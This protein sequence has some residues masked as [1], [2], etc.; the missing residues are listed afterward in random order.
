MKILI[1]DDHPIVVEALSQIIKAQFPNAKVYAVETGKAIVQKL[2]TQKI[3]FLILDIKLLDGNSLAVLEDI[4]TLDLKV[5][6]VVFSTTHVADSFVKFNKGQV[7][8][9]VHKNIQNSDLRKIVSNFLLQKEV[10]KIDSEYF[11][12]ANTLGKH[13]NT[14]KNLFETLSKNELLVM[15]LL[16]NDNST[17]EI[18]AITNKKSNTIS[19][20]K[21][22]IFQKLGIHTVAEFI[23]ILKNRI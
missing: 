10:Y 23:D 20:Y 7:W 16:A 18:A 19:T 3:D 22:R 6:I 1:A 8:G 15:E 9:F 14:S 21:R 5:N 4:K 13:A 2:M 17:K 11:T 12:S